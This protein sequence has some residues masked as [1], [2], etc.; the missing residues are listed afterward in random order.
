MDRHECEKLHDRGLSIAEISELSGHAKSKLRTWKVRYEWG[1]KK[2]ATRYK[3]KKKKLHATDASVTTK[4]KTSN[5]A[6]NGDNK[7]PLAT[8]KNPKSNSP[9]AHPGNQFAKGNKGGYAPI[10][11]KNSSKFDIY[12]TLKPETLPPDKRDFLLHG[13]N[14]DRIADMERQ[15]RMIDLKIVDLMDKIATWEKAEDGIVFMETTKTE[16][17]ERGQD[18]D[19]EQ[20][21]SANAFTLIDK[22]LAHINQLT[23]TKNRIIRDIEELEA[24]RRELPET[25]PETQHNPLSELSL[26]EL[27]KLLALAEAGHV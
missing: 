15:A 6:N 13:D 10:G 26:E 21:K 27:R 20:R 25:E 24:K 14:S 3:D 1:K 8:D 18:S 9:Y 22:A 7:K 19:Y 12:S 23:R 11:N 2:A 16:G 5:V 4:N 17:I